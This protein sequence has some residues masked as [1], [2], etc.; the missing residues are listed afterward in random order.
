MALG[1]GWEKS[2]NFCPAA[3][4][5]GASTLAVALVLSYASDFLGNLAAWV[6]GD[7]WPG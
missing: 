3:P 2:V 5:P 7:D 6:A 1:S 4:H